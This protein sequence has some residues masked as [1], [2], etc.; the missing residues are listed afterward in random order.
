MTNKCNRPSSQSLTQSYATAAMAVH[1]VKFSKD[2]KKGLNGGRATRE[3][4]ELAHAWLWAWLLTSCYALVVTPLLTL[5]WQW[6]PFSAYGNVVTPGRCLSP[7]WYRLKNLPIP[8]GTDTDTDTTGIGILPI[9]PIPIP[10]ALVSRAPECRAYI[11][12]IC[13]H[14]L[15]TAVKFINQNW[16]NYWKLQIHNS[17]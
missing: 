4:L 3:A 7:E 9:P 11:Y 6:T 14:G 12:P 1:S 13:G 2:N 8:S 5:R 15:G 17:E 16:R 10:T